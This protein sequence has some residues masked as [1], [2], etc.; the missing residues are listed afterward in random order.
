M[1]E[2]RMFH[3]AVVESDA[4]LD[5][6]A[7]AQALYFHLGMHA[8][9]DGFVNGP[10]QI[11]RKLRRPPRELKLL[12]D[13]G[14]LLTFDGIVVLKH[15]RMANTLQNDRI[16]PV[17]YPEIAQ[18]LYIRENKIYTTTPIE[19]MEDLLAQRKAL[20]ESGRNPKGKE[21]KRKEMKG[22][23][24][25]RTEPK[26]IRKPDSPERFRRN[27]GRDFLRRRIQKIL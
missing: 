14:F 17:R 19:G 8:D 2:R 9:D 11:A 18:K 27:P 6:P 24:M 10:R 13:Q 25:N 12:E 20:M 4:F 26:G 16:K 22:T 15:W 3:A 21:R 1:A 5:M 23:E 7:G